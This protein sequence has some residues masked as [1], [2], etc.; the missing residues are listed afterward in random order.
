MMKGSWGLS[1]ALWSRLESLIPV[2][3][4]KAHPYGGHRRRVGNRAA[5]TAILFV[6]RTGCQ[7]NALNGT[8]I[9]SSS[10][11]HRRFQEWTKAGVFERFWQEGLQAYDEVRGI[12]WS[13]CAMD[14]AQSKAPLAGPKKR[15]RTRRTGV[16]KGSSAVF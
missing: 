1:D 9:C 14:S 8:G 7:W 16:S 6:L 4:P 3:V 5:M 10:S 11:A 13:W 2:H 15:E 12:D